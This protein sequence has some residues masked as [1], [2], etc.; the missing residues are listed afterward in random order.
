MPSPVDKYFE[1]VKKNNPSYSDAQAWATAWSIYCKHKN[2]GSE[3]CHQDEYLTGKRAGVIVRVASRFLEGARTF[4]DARKDIFDLLK[5]EG[6]KVVEGLK[7]PH[8]TSPNGEL[9]L[10]FKK[11]AVYF[12]EGNSH[13]FGGARTI[14]YGLDIRKMTAEQFLSNLKKWFPESL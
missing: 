14:T 7:I 13:T 5:R 2:P 10:W 12:T 4:D 9:R 8:A 1:E 3:H 11:Q 6:W